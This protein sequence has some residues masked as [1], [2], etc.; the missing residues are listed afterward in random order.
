MLLIQELRHVIDIF[1]K[2]KEIFFY[3][4]S[5]FLDNDFIHPCNC[6]SKSRGNFQGG[7]ISIYS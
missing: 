4:F 7:V 6:L 1:K 5:S 3:L 2:N